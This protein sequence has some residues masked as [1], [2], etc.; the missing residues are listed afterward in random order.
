MDRR[1]LLAVVSAA[2]LATGLVDLSVA[3]RRRLS[4][5]PIGAHL[6]LSAEHLAR[7]LVVMGTARSAPGLMLLTQAVATATLWKRP[8]YG[9]TR[10]LG[11]LGAIMTFGYLVER[12]SPLSPGHR[13][14]IGTPVFAVG[15]LG[16][17]AMAWLGL[18]SAK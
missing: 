1:H 12:G 9:A 2:Q 4:S 6:N 3:V 7:D 17:I 8:S 10:S 5:D 11:V 13:E 18:R 14:L 16:A 15:F